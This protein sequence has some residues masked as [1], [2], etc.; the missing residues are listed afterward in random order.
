MGTITSI[1]PTQQQAIAADA[2][3]FY[4]KFPTPKQGGI[5]GD[6]FDRNSVNPTDAIDLYTIDGA[7]SEVVGIDS[8]RRLSMATGGTIGN[9]ASVRTNISFN[10]I[11]PLVDTRSSIEI[12]VIFSLAED[13]TTE[14]FIG[15]HTGDA[16]LT[17]LPTTARHAGIFWDVSADSQDMFFTSGNGTSQVTSSGMTDLLST[18]DSRL[19]RLNLIWN[20]DDN[21]TMEAFRGSTTDP[22]DFTANVF[23][24]DTTVTSF[25]AGSSSLT[26]TQLHFFVQTE[27]SAAKTLFIDEWRCKIT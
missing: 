11:I 8:Q 9:D 6:H 13:T 10:R 5:I 27:A 15:L 19:V 16:A 1:S 7:G 4:P 22:T 21:I 23:N 24:S 20:G 26:A 25:L 3:I 14:G 18:A 17:A 12:D 2:E